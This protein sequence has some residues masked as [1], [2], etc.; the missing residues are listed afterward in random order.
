MGQS[1]R[2]GASS[3]DGNGNGSAENLTW[4]LDLEPYIAM[5]KRRSA[6]S[7]DGVIVSEWTEL[8]PEEFAFTW[9]RCRA[10]SERASC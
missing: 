10:L 7:V 3:E 1:S 9:N 4:F 6:K 5:V 2:D 8:T